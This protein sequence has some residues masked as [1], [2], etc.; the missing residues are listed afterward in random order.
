V[1]KKLFAILVA[2]VLVLTTA[3]GAALA[4]ERGDG[5][6]SSNQAEG[7]QSE[8]SN[9][10]N[11]V[12]PVAAS[13]VETRAQDNDGDSG[14]EVREAEAE[15]GEEEGNEGIELEGVIQVLTSTSLTVDGKII[16]LT[17]ATKVEG[18][19]AIGASVEVEAVMK[20]GSLVAV[21][22]EVK[23]SAATPPA[24]VTLP[25]AP[26]GLTATAASAT[27]VNLSWA[28][29]SN[30]ET[31][32][33]IQRAT[34]SG[35]SSG[36]ATFTVGANVTTYADTSAV[37]STIYY[38]RVTSYNS[39]GD[40]ASSGASATTP[41]PPVTI[42]AAPTGLTATAASATRVNLAWTDNSNNETGFHI[43]RATDSGFTSGLTTFTVGANVTTYADTSV[44]ASTIYYYRVTSYNSAGDSSATSATATTPAPPVTIP[45][46][47]TGLTATAASAS[48]VNLSWADNSNNEA[49]F[50][51]QRATDSGFING[52]TTFTVGANVT[53]YAD[54][55]VVAS[56]IYY[57]RVTAY[58]SAGDSSATSATATTPAAPP[59][60]DAAQIYANNC[61]VC[62][63]A[64]RQGNVGP[65]L[66]PTSLASRTITWITSFISGHR[67]GFTTAEYTALAD[68]LKN[69]PP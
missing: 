2:I 23:K 21:K 40:S 51:I 58:N 22:I 33:H 11:Y 14:E 34:D 39:A 27:W 67:S 50:H 41:A 54:T 3:G 26:T 13:R 25:A 10:D 28:D 43:Q 44:V 61:A 20:G 48:R 1:K 57:Y 45:V 16:L 7:R 42:P 19:L 46:A 6:K 52:L 59:A 53:T 69:T 62:H 64:S 56:T 5:A 9:S 18:N 17:E 35:F 55:S 68:W 4:H 63:G 8:D 24:P 66:T 37:A 30:N 65:A 49:G 38:Y 47:P 29:N 15:A 60:I 12:R 36:L 31:G 32:F